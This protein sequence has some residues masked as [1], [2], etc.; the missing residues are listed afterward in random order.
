MGITRKAWK[1]T[2]L[3][4]VRQLYPLHPT[5]EIAATLG[6]TIE[7]I[8]T[9]AY[10]MGLLKTV[11]AKRV[12]K[13]RTPTLNI[14][15]RGPSTCRHIA[16]TLNCRRNLIN[17]TL[18]KLQRDGLVVKGPKTER[19]GTARRIAVLWSLA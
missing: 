2:D 5:S 3:I 19:F 10:K 11:R 9:Q 8:A 13:R 15:R 17:Q 7:A 1:T 6:R 4:L 16:D 18:W 12:D 14:L